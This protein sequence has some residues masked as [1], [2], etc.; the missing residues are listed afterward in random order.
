MGTVEICLFLICLLLLLHCT[1][2]GDED[3]VCALV[4]SV[5]MALFRD[6]V[7]GSKRFKE[8]V[9]LNYDI[10]NDPMFVY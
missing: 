1:S 7:N 5:N 10:P 4:C 3:A 9:N 6:G 8:C 2:K